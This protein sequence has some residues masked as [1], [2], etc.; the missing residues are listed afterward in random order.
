M[1]LQAIRKFGECVG[2]NVLECDFTNEKC[3]EQ[4]LCDELINFA[5]LLRIMKYCRG[6]ATQFNKLAKYAFPGETQEIAE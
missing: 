5:P 4:W 3:V 2:F 6:K 1:K